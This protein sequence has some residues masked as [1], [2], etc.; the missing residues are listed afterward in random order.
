MTTSTPLEV[1]ADQALRQ[2]P[3]PA[4]RSLAVLETEKEIVLSGSVGSYYHKQ[5]AQ[6]AVMPILGPRTLCNR[7]TVVR[8]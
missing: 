1:R 8:S 4:L 7:V 2:S 5:L 3:I 6:E